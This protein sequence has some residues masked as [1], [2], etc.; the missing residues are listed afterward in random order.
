[1]RKIST[2]LFIA[3]FVLINTLSAQDSGQ[4]T[5][6]LGL[7]FSPS[8]D[9]MSPSTANYSSDGVVFG[10]AY[11]VNMDFS[12]GHSPNYFINTGLQ[13]KRTGGRLSYENLITLPSYGSQIMKVSRKYK[14]DY[15]RIPVALKLKTNPFGRFAYYGFFG[16]DVD[17]RTSAKAND[18]YKFNGLNVT[19]DNININDDV[20]LFRA[21]LYL[22]A[23]AEYTISGNTKA[24]AGFNFGNG[25]SDILSGKNNGLGTANENAVAKYVELTFGF[26][27]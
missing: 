24:Y 26:L 27:F 9:W 17:I 6:I 22:G 12:L 16:L 20:N 5:F 13:M 15:L 7:N 1:M 10:Y 18:E 2:S 21:G 11:G 19:E 8:L 3:L 4:K 25:F 14:V 23:G